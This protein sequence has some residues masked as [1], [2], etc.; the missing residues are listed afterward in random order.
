MLVL[1][2]GNV[3]DAYHDALWAMRTIGEREESR[4]GPVLVAPCPV[5]TI[6][7]RPW[8]RVLFNRTRR[9]NP[10]FHLMESMWMMAGQND[11]AFVAEYNSQMN[12]YADY[13]VLVGA[14]GARWRDHWEDE[15]GPLDQI[16]K[17]IE[18]LTKDPQTRRAVITMWDP[19]MD[20][21]TDNSDI[22]CNTQA[23]FRVNKGRLEMTLT[24]RSNDIIWGAYGANAVHF[25]ILHELI[26]AGAG[27]PQ[28]PMY[29][30]SNNWHI[31]ERHW[32]LLQVPEWEGDPYA[33]FGYTPLLRTA[34]R[35]Q[36]F[37]EDAE[38]LTTVSPENF[39]FKTLFFNDVVLPLF[40]AWR[41][42]KTGNTKR[43]L[44]TLEDA[45]PS[46]WVSSARLWLEGVK[47]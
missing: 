42:H 21:G 10:F 46:D 33:D 16:K 34:E 25:S 15:E 5:C 47:K 35:W 18:M 8:E 20:L 43:A 38:V 14:Y 9:P 29:Q 6:Y 30:I 44:A 13:G 37:L 1:N 31:Y 24:C 3:N 32:E 23:Y 2:A 7:N 19:Y 11:V 40:F 27:L 17:I 12:A 28:G 26:A 36:D 22:P 45:P 41:H 4:N 39:L